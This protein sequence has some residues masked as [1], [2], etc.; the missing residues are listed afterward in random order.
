M[1]QVIPLPKLKLSPRQSL[2]RFEDQLKD[3]LR[4]RW[5]SFTSTPDRRKRALRA[6]K[7]GSPI[8]ALLLAGLGWWVFGPRLQ[9]NY[10]TAPIDDVF[11]YT[12][13]SDQFNKLPI[14]KSLEPI[15]RP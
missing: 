1:S 13:L 4:T 10:D 3:G 11:D 12:M 15:G 14:P 5:A 6:I 9:P 8:L 7:F 2:S